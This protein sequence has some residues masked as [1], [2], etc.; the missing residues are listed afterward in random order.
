MLFSVLT[1]RVRKSD[2]DLIEVLFAVA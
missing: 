1:P 2:A